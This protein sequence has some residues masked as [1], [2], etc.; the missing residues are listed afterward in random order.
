MKVKRLVASVGA[1]FEQFVSKME[2]HQ[3][4]ASCVIDDMRNSA[5]KVRIE[6]NRVDQRIKTFE[7]QKS[8]LINDKALW[9]KR[10]KQ[11]MGDAVGDEKAL[12]C[13]R[14]SKVIEARLK[15]VEDQLTQSADL[16]DSLTHNIHEV[17]SKIETME[18]RRAMLS[19]REARANIFN[20][21]QGEGAG[22]DSDAL[23]DRWEQD[24]ISHEY[25]DASVIPSASEDG[26]D[27][28]LEREFE[29]REETEDLAAILAGMKSDLMSE[30]EGK[31]DEQ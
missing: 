6:V 13:I 5:A 31:K 27:R 18:S 19:S 7:A 1:S 21:M 22:L 9:L 17:E 14:Q 15:V 24:V 12:N 29:S 16:Y 26:V 23:F 3:A 4:V 10:A 30:T 2:N 28:Q 20:K 8:K 11:S 25:R